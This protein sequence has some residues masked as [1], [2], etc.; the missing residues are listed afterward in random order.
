MDKTQLHT[1][2]SFSE[3]TDSQ[4]SDF[5]SVLHEL[6]QNNIL[7]WKV[8]HVLVQQK[9][10]VVELFCKKQPERETNRKEELRG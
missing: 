10:H 8:K 6:E 5:S 9:H 1:V 3:L 7:G 2:F 4:L